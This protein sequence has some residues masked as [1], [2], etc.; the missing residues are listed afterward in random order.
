MIS[1]ENKKVLERLDEIE[2]AFKKRER[3]RWSRAERDA[4]LKRG[5]QPAD[6]Y[7][8]WDRLVKLWAM[9]DWLGKYSYFPDSYKNKIKEWEKE[10]KY[11]LL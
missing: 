7:Q 11:F 6:F 9:K 8:V 3:E 2:G 10:L 4:V 1:K 5:E